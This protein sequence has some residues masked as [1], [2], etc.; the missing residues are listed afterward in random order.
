MSAMEVA[1]LIFACTFG[2]ANLGMY[3]TLPEDHLSAE[4]KD[5]IK[6][7]TGFVATMAAL[8]IS[9]MVSSA[10]S[11]F[12]QRNVE[13]SDA[14]TDII[15]LDRTL[16]QY[17][18]DSQ[19]VRQALHD[20]TQLW[21]T[22]FWP[23]VGGHTDFDPMDTGKPPIE[24]VEEGVRTLA[25]ANDVQRQ[26]QSEALEL[27]N[28]L[29]RTSWLLYEQFGQHSVPD[30]FL[31]VLGIWLTTI[32]TSFGLFARRNFTITVVF[33]VCALSAACAILLILEM[34]DPFNGL[35]KLSSV[36]LEETLARLGGK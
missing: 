3:L 6:L 7:G 16:E 12:D 34:D 19:P 1:L 15:L 33:V 8:V 31:V 4:S 14:A 9:L 17:G 36:P 32:F 27:A 2:G 24:I 11:S 5:V 26:L 22:R 28:S 13:L 35:V 25:P 10:K 29:M 23:E 20:M 18:P 30:V 21:L